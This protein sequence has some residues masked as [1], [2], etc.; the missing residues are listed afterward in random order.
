MRMARIE[1]MMND[2]FFPRG[3]P[4]APFGLRMYVSLTTDP[5]TGIDSVRWSELWTKTLD[6]WSTR[7]V[8]R[9]TAHGVSLV[10]F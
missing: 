7:T 5:I 6:P 8:R 4:K 2:R 10:R 9:K 1:M 3:K